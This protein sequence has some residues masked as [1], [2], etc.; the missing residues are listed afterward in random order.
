MFWANPNSLPSRPATRLLSGDRNCEVT[1]VARWLGESHRQVRHPSPLHHRERTTERPRPAGP[2]PLPGGAGAVDTRNR[3]PL[4]RRQF[5]A[6]GTWGGHRRSG[7]RPAGREPPGAAAVTATRPPSRRTKPRP[8]RML[9]KSS[10]RTPGS[11]PF[12]K[13]P[14][15]RTRSP[16]SSIVV[17]RC[18][19]TT[20]TTTSS[21]CSGAGPAGGPAGDGFT[22]ARTDSRTATNPYPDGRLQRAFRMPTTCQPGAAES[23]VDGQPQRVRQRRQRRVR[24]D[25]I[26]PAPRRS[27]APWRWATGRATTCRSPTPSPTT[28]PIGDRWFCSCSRRPTPTAAT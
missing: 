20:R 9:G 22:L 10:L 26:R 14:R 5:L 13:L 6:A 21:G 17:V 23:G 11:L 15:A 19:R 24:P 1:P 8:W 12:P 27:S 7:R 3:K 18:S 16:R 2:E 28:F 25:V 4:S